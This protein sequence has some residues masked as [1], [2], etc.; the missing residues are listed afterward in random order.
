MKAGDTLRFEAAL[1]NGAVAFTA[2]VVPKSA[3][4]VPT[5]TVGEIY[6]LGE[7]QIRVTALTYDKTLGWMVDVEAI[8]GRDL[9]FDAVAA[10]DL[11]PL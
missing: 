1:D 4:Y 2:V 6:R 9:Q 11:K 8:D 3:P 7:D 10:E 5:I